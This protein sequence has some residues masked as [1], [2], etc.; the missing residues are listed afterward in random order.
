MEKQPSKKW[1]QTGPNFFPHELQ[2]GFPVIMHL[3]RV[4]C[5]AWLA[6]HFR[7][8]EHVISSHRETTCM[9]ATDADLIQQPQKLDDRGRTET[10]GSGC[11]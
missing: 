11:S 9:H 4:I 6:A 7:E 5:R 10:S 2:H 8:R 3:F 1:C